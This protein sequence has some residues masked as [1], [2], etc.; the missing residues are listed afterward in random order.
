M[1]LLLTLLTSSISLVPVQVII[2]QPQIKQSS[3]NSATL[4]C[5]ITGYPRVQVKWFKLQRNTPSSSSFK[6]L[7]S[8]QTN[9]ELDSTKLLKLYK[10]AIRINR[11][12][13]SN[14]EYAELN[15]NVLEG[16]LTEIQLANNVYRYI[17]INGTLDAKY[18][19]ENRMLEQFDDS[20]MQS[21]LTIQKLDV[22]DGL[23]MMILNNFLSLN[24]V[25]FKF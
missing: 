24:K 8:S 3:R 4:L 12:S 17:Q 11:H 6:S 2:D 25:T 22:D 18:T 10:E 15:S 9:Q 16:G 1:S 13:S 14:S 5:N 20:Q 21:M 7:S 19:I 23:Y